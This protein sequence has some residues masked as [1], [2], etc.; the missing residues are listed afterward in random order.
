[1]EK[2]VLPGLAGPTGLQGVLAGFY[3]FLMPKPVKTAR[4]RAHSNGTLS[5]LSELV[6]L[7]VLTVLGQVLSGFDCFEQF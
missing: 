4:F 2:P 5:K 3:G 1:M 6:V 7:A